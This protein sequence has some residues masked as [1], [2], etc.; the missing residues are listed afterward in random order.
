[1]SVTVSI[2]KVYPEQALELLER[3]YRN[4]KL[5]ESAVQRMVRDIRAG[6]WELNGETIKLAED[7]TLLDGQNRLTA[8]VVAEL[9]IDLIVVRGLKAR[10]QD[11]VDTGVSR[12]LSDVL[13]MRGYSN[14]TH[15]AAAIRLCMK[16]EEFHS[17]NREAMMRRQWAPTMTE[18]L[19]WFVDNGG[20]SA[21]LDRYPRGIKGMSRTVICAGHYLISKIDPEGADEFF[22]AVVSPLGHTE[23]SP[24]YQLRRLVE[25]ALT[26]GTGRT[27]PAEWT[28]GL[29][30]KAANAWRQDVPLGALRF[31]MWGEGAEKTYPRIW[32]PE[33]VVA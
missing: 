26:G 17:G 10:V 14:A 24:A 25:G 32:E 7:G 4:R 22:D 21:S 11:T 31:R 20:L 13:H 9:P 5:K 15:L 1:M 6:K 23:S 3:N 29:A 18:A 19:R 27:N 28:L 30:I 12:G 33:K 16:Y 2:E 8:C